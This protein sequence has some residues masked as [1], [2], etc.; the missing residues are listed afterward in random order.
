MTFRYTATPGGYDTIFDYYDHIDECIVRAAETEKYNDIRL[1]EAV[2]QHIPVSLHV[3]QTE[4]MGINIT[5]RHQT[6]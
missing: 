1:W 6:G 3:V 5:A 2:D 4:V